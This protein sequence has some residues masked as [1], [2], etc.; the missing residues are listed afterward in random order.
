MLDT[1]AISVFFSY[2]HR[3]EALRDEL[4]KH[5]KLLE[6]QGVITSWHDRE[7]TAGEEWK[8]QIDQYLESSQIILL[9]ISV[10]FL[11]S[12]YCY[13][14]EMKR[15]MERHEAGE[16]TVIPIILRPVS[17]KTAPFA[18]LQVLP[19][20]GLAITKWQNQDEAFEHISEKLRST[21]E[22]L[23]LTQVVPPKSAPLSLWVHGWRETTFDGTPTE[24]LDWTKYFDPDSP[25]R[26]A[27]QK[28]WDEQLFPDLMRAKQSFPYGSRVQVSG[29]MPLS[30]ALAIGTR[31]SDAERYTLQTL[32][33]TAG[34]DV[35]WSSDAKKSDE[36]FHIV[37]EQGQVGENLLFMLA[38]RDRAV[39]DLLQ[40]YRQ[41]GF[42]SMVY[43][44]PVSGV[45][46]CAI[47][48]SADAVAL[49]ID[50]MRLIN[51]CRRRYQAQRV[52]LVLYCPMG[53]ALFL[54][55]R[56]R[57]VEVVTYELMDLSDR[58][59]QVSVIL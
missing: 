39:D 47:A 9:L 45:G 42:D 7:I 36:T 50:A 12:D 29:L 32:Q 35:L 34:N 53:F 54:G 16:A 14:L 10:D 43:A 24:K 13:D 56:L 46:E 3:D 25:R 2:S 18:K 8:N 5:L 23:S 15:A 49:A 37:K 19:K 44:E 6:R 31:F 57:F 51:D 33:R 17:W 52:H 58:T 26:I 4:A 1:S 41:G 28:I 11:S 48:S 22:Q 20:D 40:L 59:Y 30:M 27:D 21:I 55:Q 38:I